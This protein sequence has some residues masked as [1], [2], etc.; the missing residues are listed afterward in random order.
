[1]WRIGF[2]RDDRKFR[3]SPSGK[4]TR[5][6]PSAVPARIAAP[7]CSS[8]RAVS[9]LAE[10]MPAVPATGIGFDRGVL[11]EPAREGEDDERGDGPPQCRGEAAALVGAAPPG[12]RDVQQA[13]RADEGEEQRRTD[14]G[15]VA[16]V[17]QPAVA[18]D[19]AEKTA[20]RQRRGR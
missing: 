2:G 3:I 12:D 20:C 5:P 9:G 10:S 19:E 7:S 8:S 4:T 18:E 11:P 16:D 6:S 15:R 1:M 13:G 14:V 17:K